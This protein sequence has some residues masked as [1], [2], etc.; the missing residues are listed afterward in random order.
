M[1]AGLADFALSASARAASTAAA[2]CGPEVVTAARNGTTLTAETGTA[3][4]YATFTL[5]PPAYF[6]GSLPSHTTPS[7][8]FALRIGSFGSGVLVSAAASL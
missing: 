1:A 8:I 2:G 6:F 5:K 4:T 7:I 3:L